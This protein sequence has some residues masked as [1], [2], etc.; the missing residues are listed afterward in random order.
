MMP[1]MNPKKGNLK[2]CVPKQSLGT[3]KKDLTGFGN[4]SG[5]G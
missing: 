3:R 5:L 1:A 4:L 2:E